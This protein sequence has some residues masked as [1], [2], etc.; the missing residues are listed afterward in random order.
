V[1]EAIRRARPARIDWGG[2]ARLW[3]RVA[4]EWPLARIDAAIAAAGRADRRLKDVSLADDRGVLL[5]LVMRLAHANR[6]SP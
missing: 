4:E 2:S 1:F 6:E 5:D 3:G